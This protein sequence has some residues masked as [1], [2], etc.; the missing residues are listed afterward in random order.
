M[1]SK[2]ATEALQRH[3]ADEEER[4]HNQIAEAL[5]RIQHKET[6]VI[7][8]KPLQKVSVVNLAREAGISRGTL[9]NNHRALLSK[10][11][12]INEKLGRNV[13]VVRKEREQKE[14]RQSELLKQLTLDKENF[15]QENYRLQQRVN[16]LEGTVEALRSQLGEQGKVVSMS[17]RKS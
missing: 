10:L 11:D 12:K 3:K 14:A 13:S 15:A 8:L 6:R 2:R 9:Y 7:D 16:E 4:I 5:A 17:N 1:S